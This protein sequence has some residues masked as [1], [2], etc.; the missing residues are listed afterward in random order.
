MLFFLQFNF[1]CSTHLQHRHATRQ[2]CKTLLQFLAVIIAIGVIDFV[3]D[4][5]DAA[6]NIGFVAGAFDDGRFIFGHDNFL[7]TSQQIEGDVLQLQTDFF[8]N[9]LTLGQDRHVLQHRLATIAKTWGLDRHALECAANFVHHQRGECFTLNVFG[10]DDELFAR[11]HHFFEHRQHVA[12]CRNFGAEEQ[13]IGVFDH[14]FHAISVGDEIWRDVTLIETHSLN[15]V[16]FD[17]EGLAFF[18]GDHTV[19]AHLVDSF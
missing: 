19:F 1:G 7:G 6:G 3:F 14:C 10:D 9:D 4:L 12:N 17:A 11:L 13:N 5:A 15:E 18:H 16:H 2:L 8:A